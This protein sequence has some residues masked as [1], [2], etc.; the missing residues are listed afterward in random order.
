MYST[1]GIEAVATITELR[2]DTSGLVEQAK[3]INSGI[4]I[5]KNNKPYAVLISYD[6]YSELLEAKEKMSKKKK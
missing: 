1:E 4:L 3:K 6:M 2:S 5:Q